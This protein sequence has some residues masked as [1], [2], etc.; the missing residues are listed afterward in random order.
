VCSARLVEKARVA[1]PGYSF[2]DLLRTFIRKCLEAEDT[3]PLRKLNPS[4]D[5]IRRLHAIA[6]SAAR[7]AHELDR[8][9][10]E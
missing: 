1:R 8:K 10:K 4:Q 7:L 5:R 3:K 2:G 9:V 6:R